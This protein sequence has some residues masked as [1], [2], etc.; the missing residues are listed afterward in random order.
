MMHALS[1]PSLVFG[2][3]GC[4]RE[5]GT[6][7]VQCDCSCIL[8]L[9]THLYDTVAVQSMLDILVKGEYYAEN[10]VR[11]SSHSTSVRGL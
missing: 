11:Y 4:V 3:W 2:P 6:D 9:P 8:V 10:R 1:S 5:P 7:I